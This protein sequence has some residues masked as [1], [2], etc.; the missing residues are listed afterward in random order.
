MDLMLGRLCFLATRVYTRKRQ[1]VRR[2]NV[3]F[4]M[5]LKGKFWAS[6]RIDTVSF[7]TTIYPGKRQTI[8]EEML[9]F[10]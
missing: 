2:R 8:N 1:T 4:K 9:I 5:E 3:D 7:V 6:C 10:K